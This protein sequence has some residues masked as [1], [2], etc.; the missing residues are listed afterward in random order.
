MQGTTKFLAIW[1]AVSLVLLVGCSADGS[2]VAGPDTQPAP[3][4]QAASRIL[5]TFRF[6]EE[7]HFVLSQAEY[8]PGFDV[9]I[10]VENKIVVQVFADRLHIHIN[11][12]GT[13][14]NLATGF[15]LTDNGNWTDLVRLDGEGNAENVSTRGSVF[16][17]TIPGL[18]I[19][20]LDAGIITFDPETGEVLFEGGPHGNFHLGTDYCALLAAGSP[21]AQ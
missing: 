12:K 2:T 4:G 9:Q 6:T 15:V 3:Q 21:V 20:Q 11:S 14:T 10:D 13:Q 8:C 1:A 19:V 16:H 7:F 5:E 17:I 18:G